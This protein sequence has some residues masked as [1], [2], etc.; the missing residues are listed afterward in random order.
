MHRGGDRLTVHL[1]PSQGL[2]DRFLVVSGPKVVDRLYDRGE[3]RLERTD[4]ARYRCRVRGNFDLLYQ[5]DQF[6]VLI[7]RW[8]ANANLFAHSV[9]DRLVVDLET[10]LFGDGTLV[11]SGTEAVDRLH[12]LREVCLE[13]TDRTRDR[14]GVRGNLDLPYQIH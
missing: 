4:R 8:Q 3:V 13:R 14:C 11:V 1:K 6:H 9:R 2:E 10:G 7:G 5:L 12:D